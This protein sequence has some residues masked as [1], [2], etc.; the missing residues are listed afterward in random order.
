MALEKALEKAFS[1]VAQEESRDL[2][3]T[4]TIKS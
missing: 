4:N 2:P 1:K 3:I